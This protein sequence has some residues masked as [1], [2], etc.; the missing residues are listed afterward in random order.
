MH[1]GICKNTGLVY[2]GM[3]AP[4]IPSLP[5]PSIT[6]AKLIESEA[7][8]SDL[9]RDL[10]SDPLRWVFREDSFDP[11]ARMRRG[12]LYEPYAGQSQPSSQRVSP[13][14]YEDPMMRSVGTGGQVVKMLYTY[15]TCQALL[16]KP[17]QGQGMTLALGSSQAS[18]AW[19]II[20]AEALA[21]GAVMLTLKSLSAYAILPALNAQNVAE[22]Y[23]PAINQAIEKVLDSVFRESP[24]SVIDQCRAAMTVLLSRWLAQNS[25]GDET[26]FGLDLGELAKKLDERKLHCVA[27]AAQII[28]NLHARG[29]PN[30]QHAKGARPPEIGDDE[31][32]IESVGFVMREFGWAKVGSYKG[33]EGAVA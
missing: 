1:I 2:E 15:W 8:W 18:S 11:V 20:Q 24:V 12:R 10:S 7:D 13:H 21:N 32:G 27:K 33:L 26:A 30:V 23:R 9:P 3:G 4:N 17:N 31:L 28:A 16:N 25:E 14:P 22:A 29:K 19:R 5:T 6:Q